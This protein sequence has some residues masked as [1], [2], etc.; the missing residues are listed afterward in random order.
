MLKFKK[1]ISPVCS[2][3]HYSSI[4]SDRLIKFVKGIKYIEIK[5]N[6]SNEL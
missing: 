2:Y 5:I 6:Y 3:D 4:E 1:S